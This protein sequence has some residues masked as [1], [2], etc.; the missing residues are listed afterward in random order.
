MRRSL[1][2]SVNQYDLKVIHTIWFPI[3][4][5]VMKLV[6]VDPPL[7]YLTL[8]RVARVCLMPDIS[9]NFFAD[10]TLQVDDSKAVEDFNKFYERSKKEE[11]ALSEDDIPILQFGIA[12]TTFV[13]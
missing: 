13:D 9:K 5:H 8:M 3:F 10:A 4:E 6:K 12:C 2:L 7:S 1:I 11:F